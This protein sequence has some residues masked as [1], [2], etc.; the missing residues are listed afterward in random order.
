M[1]DKALRAGLIRLAHSHPEFRKDLLP[2]ITACGPEAPMQGKFEEGK[3]ADPTKNMSPEDAAEWK[4][5]TELNK[6]KFK[7]AAKGVEAGCEKLPEGGMRDNCEKK[8]EEGEKK[9]AA[10]KSAGMAVVRRTTAIAVRVLTAKPDAAD[11]GKYITGQM[12]L[13]FGGNVKPDAVRFAAHVE[14]D[15]MGNW[16]VKS[17]TTQKAVSGGGAEILLGVLQSALQEAIS[18]K[19]ADLFGA[20]F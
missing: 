11:W 12:S 20:A 5:Q 19:G 10:K 4:K 13:D 8:Q 16:A 15:D 1:S 3:P 2:L 17:F 6:D 9:E 7:G 14:P 18:T